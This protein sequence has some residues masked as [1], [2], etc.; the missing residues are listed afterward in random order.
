M[1]TK[2]RI[3]LFLNEDASKISRR[4]AL[5]SGVKTSAKSFGLVISAFSGNCAAVLGSYF[6]LL[7][8]PLSQFGVSVLF[9]DN[10]V[11]F[12][13]DGNVWS[14]LRPRCTSTPWSSGRRVS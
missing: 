7:A 11:Y 13:H 1:E 5:P 8:G 4:T 3:T 14:E 10:L 12:P 6:N 2:D 9:P